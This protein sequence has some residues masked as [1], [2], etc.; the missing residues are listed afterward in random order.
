[1]EDLFWYNPEQEGS[2]SSTNL[3]DSDNHPIDLRCADST[4]ILL[5]R[6]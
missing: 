4:A 3:P 6:D 1:M 5:L 2:E